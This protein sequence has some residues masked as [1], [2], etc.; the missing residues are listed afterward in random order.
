MNTQTWFYANMHSEELYSQRKTEL[1]EVYI[2]GITD[3][4]HNTVFNL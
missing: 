1:Y 2:I 4:L 3:L